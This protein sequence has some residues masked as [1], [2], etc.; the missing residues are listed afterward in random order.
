MRYSYINVT[1]S[2]LK[3]NKNPGVIGQIYEEYPKTGVATGRFLWWITD[4]TPTLVR[5]TTYLKLL[6][7]TT[8]FQYKPK[9]KKRKRTLTTQGKKFVL[10][11][12]CHLW[13][14]LRTWYKR[15]IKTSMIAKRTE[16][17]SINSAQVICLNNW[18]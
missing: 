14:K 11:S 13:W 5:S 6:Y 15:Q 16:S 2:S 9:E 10:C 18:T 7:Y 1:N 3:P 12:H 8:Y 17:K 4:R